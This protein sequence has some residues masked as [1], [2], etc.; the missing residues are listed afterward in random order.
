MADLTRNSAPG[1]SPILTSTDDNDD[2]DD[3]DGD[4]DDDDASTEAGMNLS[5]WR[6]LKFSN[7]LKT[8]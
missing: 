6:R 2:D 5:P 1:K 8:R 3:D 7:V 4:D